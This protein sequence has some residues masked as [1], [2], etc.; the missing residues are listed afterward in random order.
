VGRRVFAA[1]LGCLLLFQQTPLW[2]LGIALRFVDITLENV[3]PGTSVNLRV[4]KNLP[5][6]VQNLDH[7]AGVDVII[8]AVLPNAKEMKDGYEPIPDPAWVK[9]LPDHF[10]LGAAASAAADVLLTVPDDPKLIG[11]HYECIIWARTDRRDAP[12]NGGV[13]F[14]A[15]LRNRL[16]VSIGTMGP[17]SL[18]RE[19][20]LKKLAEINTDFTISPDNLFANGIPVGKMVD[21]KR[22]RKASFKIIN[23]ADTAIELKISPVQADPNIIPQ[24]GY[25]NAPDPAWLTIE[26]RQVK[27][28]GNSIKE[29]KLS[30]RFPDGPQERGKKYMFL[31]KTTLSDESLPLAYYN[32]LYISTE[33]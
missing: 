28:E 20:A 19:K 29:L 17:E 16:R 6:V 30:L 32:M 4:L 3:S 13:V 14:Q 23:Q 15:G 2:G 11:H 24:S 27:V 22:E 9:I 10:H 5:M 21:L 26:P 12:Q 7:E 33:P 31:I 1:G 8:S 18:Q 25:E